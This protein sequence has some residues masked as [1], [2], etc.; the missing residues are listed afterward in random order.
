MWRLGF[1][2]MSKTKL[3]QDIIADNYKN[4]GKEN[5]IN[6]T[7]KAIKYLENR[8]LSSASYLVYLK[9]LGIKYED[10]LEA[11]LRLENNGYENP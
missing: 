2:K 8:H 9:Q 3:T 4:G 11:E 6:S 5:V 7:V 10:I 1:K